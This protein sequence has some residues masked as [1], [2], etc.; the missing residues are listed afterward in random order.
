MKKL[1]ESIKDLLLGK[2]TKI[3]MR[4]VIDE[5]AKNIVD[6]YLDLEGDKKFLVLIRPI[7]EYIKYLTFMDEPTC[8]VKC[9]NKIVA[10]FI[11]QCIENTFY[12]GDNFNELCYIKENI[13]KEN[14]TIENFEWDEEEKYMEESI[15]LD[16]TKY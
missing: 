12:Q 3:Q 8:I 15:V 9:S 7:G 5:I 11:G 14:F 1:E 10:L 2:L 6:G 4:E 16:I 13:L